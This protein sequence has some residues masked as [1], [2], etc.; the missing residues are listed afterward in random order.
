MQGARQS[1]G[2]HSLDQIQEG[3]DDDDDAS[4][5]SGTEQHDGSEALGSSSAA[6]RQAADNSKN[7]STEKA[8]GHQASNAASSDVQ[9]VFDREALQK[10]V[11]GKG[12]GG[13]KASGPRQSARNPAAAAQTKIGKK[14]LFCT[15]S[16]CV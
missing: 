9:A 7:W 10:K 3:A 6:Q 15:A 12:P 8:N 2:D 1:N 5:S 4:E 11:G 16:S 14:V 13:R